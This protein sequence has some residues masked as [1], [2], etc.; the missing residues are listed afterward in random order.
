M[1]G[2]VWNRVIGGSRRFGVWHRVGTL[3]LAVGAV[4]SSTAG[5]CVA[6][7]TPTSLDVGGSEAS[8]VLRVIPEDR[9]AKI[10]S[11]L[12][13]AGVGRDNVAG[14]L[15]RFRDEQSKSLAA[16]ALLYRSDPGLQT[17][18]DDFADRQRDWPGGEPY[19]EE[20]EESYRERAR[21]LGERVQALRH[22][23]RFEENIQAAGRRFGEAVLRFADQL[24]GALAASGAAQ[25]GRR[26]QIRV[27]ADW[28]LTEPHALQPYKAFERSP[29]LIEVLR[30][31][32]DRDAADEVGALVRIESACGLVQGGD[33]E[34]VRA[35][36]VASEAAA[37]LA[38]VQLSAMVYARA[39]AQIDG[40]VLRA[41]AHYRRAVDASFDVLV[42]RLTQAGHLERARA[43]R[44]RFLSECAPSVMAK[45]WIEQSASSVV[46]ELKVAGMLSESA[47]R[48]LTELIGRAKSRIGEQR[49]T[50]VELGLSWRQA[51][52]GE[53]RRAKR[54]AVV[55]AMRALDRIASESRD[56][57]LG[58]L[59]AKWEASIR[60]AA[61]P[62]RGTAGRPAETCLDEIAQRSA[63]AR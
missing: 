14:I 49:A 23:A 6:A 5:A 37:E 17:F 11:V 50:L 54:H 43:V 15:D 40:Q 48:P 4:Q 42:T 27:L 25:L 56:E 16:L 10:E 24:Q 29:N 58:Q 55:Q 20:A 39:A 8:A 60:L 28:A 47:A 41:A 45:T 33:E 22:E 63:T 18:A 52:D 51:D 57:L 3:T 26:L 30:S 9:I 19:R 1:P 62:A 31:V 12:L 34:L 21:Q 7:S 32:S 13:H 61:H 53:P 44:L 2:R 46:A 36:D 35:I 38:R 59:P